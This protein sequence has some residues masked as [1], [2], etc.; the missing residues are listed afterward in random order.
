V[1]DKR[2]PGEKKNPDAVAIEALGSALD[3]RLRRRKP[4]AAGKIRHPKPDEI[5]DDAAQN[6]ARRRRKHERPGLALPARQKAGE[7]KLGRPR[8]ERQERSRNQRGGEHPGIDRK[9][10]QRRCRIGSSEGSPLRALKM[11]KKRQAQAALP[12][13]AG[14][15]PPFSKAWTRL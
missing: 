8:Q 4:A 10:S 14:F 5:I 9:F 7:N 2:Q 15:A 12:A 1:A 13:S 6:I 11:K 3:L